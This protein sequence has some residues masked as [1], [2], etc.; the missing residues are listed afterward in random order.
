[1]NIEQFKHLDIASFDEM[2]KTDLQAVYAEGQCII[3]KMTAC[4]PQIMIVMDAISRVLE[5]KN[6]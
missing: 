3:S 4:D 5:A 1:M 2:P 6:K